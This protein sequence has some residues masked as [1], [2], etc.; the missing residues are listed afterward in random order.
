MAE[1]KIEIVKKEYKEKNSGKENINS[2]ENIE[3]V[4]KNIYSE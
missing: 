2:N 3:R 1:K 4:Q